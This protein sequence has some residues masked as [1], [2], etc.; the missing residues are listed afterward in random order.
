MRETR[1][2]RRLSSFFVALTLIAS[3]AAQG[4]TRTTWS[5]PRDI[6]VGAMGELR[7][8]IT[9]I[10]AGRSTAT[11]RFDNSESTVRVVTDVTAT[12]YRGFGAGGTSDVARGREAFGRLRVGDRVQVRAVADSSTSIAASEI[13]LLGRSTTGSTPSATTPA[14]TQR[15]EGTV[16]SI[17]AGENQFVIETTDRRILTVKGTATTPVYYQGGTYRIGNIEAGDRVRVEVDSTTRDEIRAR[18]IDVLQSV[19]DGSTGTSTTDGRTI[20][21]VFGRITRVDERNRQIR[22]TDERGREVRV[23]LATAEDV[24]GDRVRI[25]DLQTG[26][27]VEVSGRW[28][29]ET[30]IADTLRIGGYRAADPDPRTPGTTDE[31]VFGELETVVIYGEVDGELDR[32]NSFTVRDDDDRNR[33][34]TI[35]ADADFVVRTRTGEYIVA[36][37][38]KRRDRVVIKAFRDRDGNF[39]AQTVRMR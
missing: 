38:L 31:S 8:T 13:L 24:R 35:F 25:T 15:V 9:A 37:Q 39:I 30:F 18:F 26:D 6:R 2:A 5:T 3:V 27:N 14:N 11:V 12:A 10:D 22:M 36:Q 4:Q 17:R 29:G 16:R 32:G 23:D 21:S 1:T 7:G 20:T 28:S 19:S 33:T 34:L